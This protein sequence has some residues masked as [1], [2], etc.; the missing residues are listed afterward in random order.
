MAKGQGRMA[1]SGWQMA[2]GP[3]YL[4]TGPLVPSGVNR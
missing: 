4:L 1:D 3:T 2:K